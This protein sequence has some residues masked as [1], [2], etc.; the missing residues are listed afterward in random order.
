MRGRRTR[1]PWSLWAVC[2]D[3]VVVGRVHGIHCWVEDWRVA[4]P[5]CA[6]AAAFVEVGAVCAGF[7]G[8]VGWEGDVGLCCAARED[9]EGGVDGDFEVA[10][11][12]RVIH[13]GLGQT[14]D[15]LL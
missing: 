8:A 15:D 1:K 6:R 2:S 7:W 9:V 13:V 11:F 10:A 12:G 5:G 4:A 14:H 3:C